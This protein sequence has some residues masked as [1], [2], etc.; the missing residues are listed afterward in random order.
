M[1]EAFAVVC[2]LLCVARFSSHFIN[3]RLAII[4]P[5]RDDDG[6]S[7]SSGRRLSSA[8][9]LLLAPAYYDDDENGIKLGAAIGV[10]HHT[11]TQRLDSFRSLL[12]PYVKLFPLLKLY[13]LGDG[14]RGIREGA[15]C[16]MYTCR[17]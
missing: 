15:A 13:D 10:V 8:R 17:S 3:N 6:S 1:V 12:N 14:F 9:E 4:T 5:P 7:T 2:C 11:I 16:A